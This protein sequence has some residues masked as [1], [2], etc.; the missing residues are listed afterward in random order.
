MQQ[1]KSLIIFILFILCFLF[2]SDIKAQ[3]YKFAKRVGGTQFENAMGIALDSMGN[4]IVSGYFS[5]TADFD[6]GTTNY[7]LTSNGGNDIFLAKYDSAGNFVWAIHVGGAGEEFN[8]T[9][10]AVDEYGNIYLCGVFN[11]NTDFNPKGNAVIATNRG[12]QDGF[13]AKYDSTGLLQWVRGVGGALNDD[14]YRIDYKNY[15]VL[16]AGS[17]ADSSYVDDGLTITPLYGSGSADVVFGKFNPNGNLFWLNTLKGNGEDHSYNITAGINGKT[18]LT[19]TFEDT[20][21]FDSGGV[22]PDT[23]FA[24][25]LTAFTASFSNFGN[26]YWSFPIENAYPFGLKVDHN[27]DILTCGQ[28]SNFADFD[29]DADTM[30]LIAQGS[31]DGYFAKYTNGGNYVFAKRIGGN[32]SDICYTIAELSNSSILVSG[33]FFN[34]AD[35][36]P[37]V[38][39]ASLNSNGFAD[40]YLAHYDSLGNYLS[41]FGCGSPAFEFCRNMTCNSIDEVFLCGGFEQVVDFNPAPAINTLVSAGSRDGYFVKYAFPTTSVHNM[42]SADLLIY[43]NPFVNQINISDN[44]KQTQL[45][46]TD[47]LGNI[48]YKAIISAQTKINTELLSPGI[49]FL[50][51]ASGENVSTRKLLKVK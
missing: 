29:P 48:I 12:Q 25:G 41:A 47:V 39:V 36:D 4:I 3:Q 40:I 18:Y 45:I 6:P 27:G 42:S 1:Q 35:F 31:F 24:D 14:V 10:P 28:F 26:Y 33:Y 34:T 2:A 30:T 50:T 32:G 21:I 11:S 19:G 5:G 22:N 7:T 15:L 44:F 8:Y 20:L 49:Y 38:T 37:D 23:L 16:F 17:F 46:L 43:P 13:V 51:I 9:D